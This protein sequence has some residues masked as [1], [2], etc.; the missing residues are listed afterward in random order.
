[1][2]Q[3]LVEKSRNSRGWA[4]KHTA[5]DGRKSTIRKFGLLR[6]W[7]TRTSHGRCFRL[8][9]VRPSSSFFCQ[10]SFVRK[11]QQRPTMPTFNLIIAVLHRYTFLS[12]PFHLL[13]QGNRLSYSLG[14]YKYI[15][16]IAFSLASQ[17]LFR[18]INRAV[19]HLRWG[20]QIERVGQARGR[21]QDLMRYPTARD[22]CSP[23]RRH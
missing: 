5:I 4:I 20:S 15:N 8:I 23:T 12:R 7:Q 3:L 21:Y 18:S 13:V 11:Q 6:L 2:S 19:I 22:P 14:V 16:I 17:R 1:M 10:T 9:F